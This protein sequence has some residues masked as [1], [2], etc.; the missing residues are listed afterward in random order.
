MMLVDQSALF[1]L[2][3][4]HSRTKVSVKLLPSSLFERTNFYQRGL[5]SLPFAG[6]K[7]NGP[8]WPVE[9]GYARP[10]KQGIRF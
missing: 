5:V 9:T 10:D 6:K 7:N 1:H 3:G 4:G 8:G 2:S